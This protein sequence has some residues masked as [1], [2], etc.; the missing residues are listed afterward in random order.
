[1]IMLKFNQRI[2]K[3]AKRKEKRDKGR[4]IFHDVWVVS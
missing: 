4:K 2:K 1:M 3:N